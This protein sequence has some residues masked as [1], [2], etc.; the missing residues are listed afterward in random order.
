MCYRTAKHTVWRGVHTSFR[1]E[2][3]FTGWG[4]EGVK[5]TGIFFSTSL[6]LFL[7][8]WICYGLLVAD[9]AHAEYLLGLLNVEYS[10]PL[11]CTWWSV[12]WTSLCAWNWTSGIKNKIRSLIRVFQ[13][14]LAL[15]CISAH[16]KRGW[17]LC[18]CD[19]FGVIRLAEISLVCS[20]CMLLICSVF[21]PHC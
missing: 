14:P 13:L 20:P 16:K 4:S 5:F 1:P 11:L 9:G 7:F 6:F 10:W 12:L 2:F 18:L 17:S 15:V 21:V 3:F 19:T 8:L